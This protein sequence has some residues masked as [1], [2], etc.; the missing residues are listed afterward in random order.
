MRKENGL[1]H[2][3]VSQLAHVEINTPTPQASLEFFTD[4]LGLQ[5]SHRE[6]Q[7]VWL[8]AWGEFLHHSLKL[9]EAPAAGLAH[10]AWRVDG[11]DDLEPAAERLLRHGVDGAFIDGDVG[12]G[13]AFRFTMPGGHRLELVWEVERFVAPADQRSVYPDRPQKQVA[14]NATVRRLDHCTVFTSELLADRRVMTEALRFRHMDT[15]VTP[16]GEEI[17]STVTSG[18]HNH[19]YALVAPPGYRGAGE[20]NH[21]C[22]FYDTRDELLRA[23]D[24]LAEH[25]FK[26]EHGPHKHGI[27]ELFFCYLFE[28]GGNR[29]ELQTAGYW[30][31]LPDWEPVV[32]QIAEGGNFA[33]QISQ[34]PEPGTPAPPHAPPQF[35]LTET[36]GRA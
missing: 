3:Y 16:D 30:N 9:T 11:P 15:T 25:G 2:H 36:F 21:F 33:W 27:G 10:A 20:M 29:L 31:Y 18:A 14:R 26:L 5:I 1:S 6:G 23:L 17:F 7:S 32:W 22:Y 24:V 12:H 19:D 13:K 34:M 35:S 4:V 28:P 8:R